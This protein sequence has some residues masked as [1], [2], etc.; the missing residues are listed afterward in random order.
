MHNFALLL[1]QSMTISNSWQVINDIIL[2]PKLRLGTCLGAKLCFA[3]KLGNV[4]R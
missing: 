4:V 1:V 2:V 3:Q